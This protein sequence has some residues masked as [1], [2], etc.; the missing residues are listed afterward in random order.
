MSGD[1]DGNREVNHNDIDFV[2]NYIMT[3]KEPNGFNWWN[4]EMNNDGK[5]NVADIVKIINMSNNSAK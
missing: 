5:I 1:A 4:A 2:N 3:G